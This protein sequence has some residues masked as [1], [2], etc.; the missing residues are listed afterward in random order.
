MKSPS[1]HCTTLLV[2]EKSS[3]YR[4]GPAAGVAAAGLEVEAA[5]AAGSSG[6]GADLSVGGVSL[7]LFDRFFF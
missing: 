3:S 7:R 4:V 1:S 2:R 6:F 5:A